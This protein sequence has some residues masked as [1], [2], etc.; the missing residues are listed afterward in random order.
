MAATTM[1]PSTLLS[2]AADI[3]KLLGIESRATVNDMLRAVDQVAGHCRTKKE[4]A[5]VLAADLYGYD[6][7]EHRRLQ[8]Y[9]DSL[10]KGPSVASTARHYHATA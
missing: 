9:A 1:K 4:A 8:D 5:E 3:E 2:I 10:G 6:L 7:K